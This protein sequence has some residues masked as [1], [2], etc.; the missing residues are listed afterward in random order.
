M[1][2][3]R[4]LSLWAPVVLNMALIFG[5]SSVA[6]PPELPGPG[7]EYF[8]KYVHVILYAGLSAWFIR[9]RAGGWSRR[10]TLGAALTAVIFS[11]A[12]GVTDELHQYFVPPRQSDALDVAADAIGA[13]LA[14]GLLYAGIIRT[15]HGL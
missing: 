4:A 12:Y 6:Q 13:T 11:T 1:S 2:R 9:A 7:I 3:G 15:R 5:L 14:A 10:I 8:D